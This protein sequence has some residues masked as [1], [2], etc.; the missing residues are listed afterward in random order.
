MGTGRCGYILFSGQ[1]ISQMPES[2]FSDGS[3]VTHPLQ[4]MARFLSHLADLLD[5]I[6]ITSPHQ[7]RNK[8]RCD[9]FGVSYLYAL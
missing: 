1:V 2:W 3:V 5:R 7:E 8:T 9:P 6:T 4:G